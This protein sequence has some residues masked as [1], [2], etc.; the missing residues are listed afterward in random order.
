MTQTPYSAAGWFFAVTASKP[1]VNPLSDRFRSTFWSGAASGTIVSVAL[2][3]FLN[4]AISSAVKPTRDTQP[5]A[6]QKVNG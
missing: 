5:I 3:P 1:A 2:L 4:C 6:A